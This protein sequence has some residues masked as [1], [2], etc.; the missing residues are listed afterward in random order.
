MGA[1]STPLKFFWFMKSLENPK[2]VQIWIALK[3]HSKKIHIQTDFSKKATINTITNS[4]V[5]LFDALRNI[6]EL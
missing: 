2:V 4:L 5:E 1:D 6:E 3:D